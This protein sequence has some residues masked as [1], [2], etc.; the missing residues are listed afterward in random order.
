MA[1]RLTCFHGKCTMTRRGDT[2]FAH[3]HTPALPTCSQSACCIDV[4]KVDVDKALCVRVHVHCMRAPCPRVS[5]VRACP[6]PSCTCPAHT[7]AQTLFARGCHASFVCIDLSPQFLAYGLLGGCTQAPLH[8]WVHA[9]LYCVIYNNH[10]ALIRFS[11]ICVPI[12]SCVGGYALTIPPSPCPNL[13]P[14][15]TTSPVCSFTGHDHW[16]GTSP[17][18]HGLA[19]STP[20]WSSSMADSG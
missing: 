10:W 3:I 6:A 5:I 13:L 4:D 9:Y 15:A 17:L 1:R 12:W 14:S 8:I 20:T 19:A 16:G 2:R 11:G 18:N 7:C